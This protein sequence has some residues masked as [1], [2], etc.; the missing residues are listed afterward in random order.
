MKNKLYWQ[1]RFLMDKAGNINSGERFLQ[2]KTNEY[3]KEAL[4]EIQES[5]DEFYKKF[6]DK[7]N[8][9]LAEAKKRIKASDFNKIDFDKLISY[10]A[11]KNSELKK[12]KDKL[13]AD[14]IA[15]IEKQRTEYES[16]LAAYTKKGQI[17]RLELLQIEIEK[18]LLDLQDKQQIN[19][20]EHLSKEYQD[21]Y[22]KSVFNTQQAL[23][24]GKDFATIN[25]TA[26]DRAIL[27]T[28]SRD[29]YSKIIWG[30]RE[31]L[32]ADL[33]K[34][35]TTGL[36]RG[37]ALE[38]MASCISKRL[39]VSK[40][41]AYRLVRTETAYIYEQAAKRAYEE[42][43]I[44]KYKYL[45]TL[46]FKTSELC[47]ELDGKVFNVKDAMPGKNYP[48]M[49]PNC[50]SST[51]CYFDD[52]VVTT[53]LAK[54]TRGKY[55]EVPSNMNYKE[56]YEKYVENTGE[57]AII[58]LTDKEKYSLNSYVSFQSYGINDKLRRGE[59]LTKREK[60]IVR[61]LDRA[62]DKMPEYKGN[63]SRSLSFYDNEAMQEFLNQYRIN[64]TVIKKDYTSTTASSKLYNPDAQVQLYIQDS[65]KG[66]DIRQYN[67]REQEVLYK[68]GQ[69]FT[70][71]NKETVDGVVY[72]LLEEYDG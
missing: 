40:S 41:N 64:S 14:V 36:I 26:V 37:E 54:H 19:V 69:K 5:I 38:K 59:K 67:E 34:N 66:K 24:F 3:F 31:S 9:T 17:S 45:A 18:V 33:R 7:E 2:E 50:R 58:K 29:N 57:S 15:L 49:H 32:S 51:I 27:N 25:K 72:I 21:G 13:P 42:C 53:R 62:L 35:I 11:D 16:M 22:Y 39:E 48:P 6:A 68:R 63:L 1:R 30:H 44:E 56:W 71:L 4:K 46:D 23:G 8:I 60:S 43:N 20:Y 28:Y 47:R 61:G 12:L 52:D 10:Q 65:K 70:V 55:Y